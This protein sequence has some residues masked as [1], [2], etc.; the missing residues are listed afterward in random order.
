MFQNNNNENR[1][2]QIGFG[3]GELQWKHVLMRLVTIFE[4]TN[5]SFHIL[6]LRDSNYNGA[7]IIV[8]T[9]AYYSDEETQRH[10]R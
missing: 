6:R 7:E 10:I 2:P 5:L 9:E 3:L 1:L 8:I 4:S